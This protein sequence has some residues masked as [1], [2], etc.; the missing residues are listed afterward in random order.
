MSLPTRYRM[1]P[2]ARVCSH[3]HP[4]ERDRL[5]AV[6]GS[7]FQSLRHSNSELWQ[8]VYRYKY[9]LHCTPDRAARTLQIREAADAH[10]CYTGAWTTS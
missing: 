7:L 4:S 5:R 3:L 2:S 6:C 8:D 10:L 1:T 9:N